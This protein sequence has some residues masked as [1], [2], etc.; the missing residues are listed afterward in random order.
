MANQRQARRRA[1]EARR[2]RVAELM[3]ANPGISA[4]AIGRQL[5]V[6]HTT[7]AKDVRAIREE[8]AERRR[9]AYEERLVEDLIRTD[10][11][12]A[13]LWPNVAAGKGWAI[14]RL[15]SLITTRMKLLGLDMVRHEVDIGEILARYLARAAEGEDASAGA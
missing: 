6:S 9:Q 13:A 10:A 11:A 2:T 7:A 4:V 3:L 1:V 15:V 5:G 14:D 8:W 12:I